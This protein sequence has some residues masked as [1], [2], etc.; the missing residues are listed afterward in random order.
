[1]DAVDPSPL[2]RFVV[3]KRSITSI[4]DLLLDFVKDGSA[5]VDAAWRSDDLGPVAMEEQSLEMV[6][7]ATKLTAIREVVVRRH[8]KVA[9][10]GRTSNGK[11][12][13]INAMLRDRVLPSGIGHTTNC[14]L[15]VEGTDGE[16]AYLTT[17]AS[18]ERMNVSTVNQLAHALHMDPTLDSG[19]LVRVFWPKSRCALLR[20]D[21]V[22]MDSPGTDV[23]LEL[24]SWIDRFC[25][26]ADV[27]VLVGNAESTLM[28]TEK[29][30]FHKVSERISKPNIFILHNRW[31]AS[32]TEP[33]FIDEV[34][35]Q[36][37]D[38]C[39]SFLAEEL[40]VVSVDEAPQRIF[41]VSAKEVLSSRMQRA[42]GMPETGETGGALAE[43][44]HERLREFQMFE[45][46]FE[47]FISQSA[48]KTKFEQHTMRAWQITEAIKAVMD[49]I[50][51]ASADRKICCLEE[52]EE[53]RDRLD[54][55]R[56]QINRLSDSIKDRIRTLT[57]DVSAKVAMALSNQI[58][59]LPVLV[60]E[61]RADFN[62]SPETLELYKSKLLRHVEERL[63]DGLDARCSVSVLHDLRDAQ[64]H[65]TDSVRPLL[66]SSVQEQLSTPPSSFQLTYDLNL[67]AVCADFIENIDFQFSLGWTA[68]V[69]RFIG[70]TNAKRA[71]GGADPQPQKSSTFKDELVVSI[72]TGLVS[73]TSRASMTVLV[74]G[75][76][77]WRSVGWRLIALS[78]SVYGVLYLYERL[79]WTNASQERALKQQFVEHAT[80][81]L[82]AVVP[83][84]SSAC[85]QQVYK[86]LWSTF[87]R[88][89]QRVD[90]SEAELEGNVRQLSFRIQRLENIQRRSKAFRNRATELETQLEAFSIQYLQGN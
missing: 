44:F 12:T 67:S 54:F 9:F 35:K 70:A 37:L 84:T 87:S 22:L 75:G 11:S 20:D 59:S 23:T 38:R 64:S 25:L 78:V 27:F 40:K 42:Q 68:L 65:M 72:A 63:V 61:F 16:D 15:R 1:M 3:A 79:T 73:V 77:V 36:H 48:V 33:E 51:I 39:V 4:F 2:R 58:R 7:C 30:F 90:L 28:N 31:D 13:V 76:V 17:E 83:V 5:F 71:L 46:T 45:R 43:G 29:L 53:Q 74:I 26:D 49:A 8:M 14:F 69:A 88:L 81:C 32:V 21:L 52:R 18:N 60:D 34:R 85:S 82:R 66:S 86:E 56:G 24:D 57:A 41:F 10:F 50:N 80:R 47:E 19:S 6:S 55:V 89:T 62:P